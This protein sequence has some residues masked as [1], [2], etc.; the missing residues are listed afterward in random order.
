[1]SKAG[2]VELGIGAAGIYGAFMYYGLLQ[3]DVLTYEDA[4]AWVRAAER[5]E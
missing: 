1:M 5:G 2:L 3:E 4:G